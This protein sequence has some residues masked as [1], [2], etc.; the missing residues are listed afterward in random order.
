MSHTTYFFLISGEGKLATLISI[1]L[2]YTLAAFIGHLLGEKYLVTVGF[3]ST[4]KKMHGDMLFRFQT[5]FFAT[6]LGIL[7]IGAGAPVAEM[8]NDHKE[9]L[10][11][12]DRSTLYEEPY[13]LSPI[14]PEDEKFE[15]TAFTYSIIYV[16]TGIMFIVCGIMDMFCRGD[17]MLQWT[18]REDVDSYLEL[19]KKSYAGKFFRII[20]NSRWFQAIKGF[21]NGSV[22]KS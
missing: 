9:K 15:H 8:I 5:S 20:G 18:E 17:E 7:L 21:F 11:R 6:F 12:G 13:Y 4:E 1:I 3:P 22:G 10:S 16:V 19:L 2:L 14:K